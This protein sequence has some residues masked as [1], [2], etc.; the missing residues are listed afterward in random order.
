M[1]LAQ[2]TTTIVVRV[3]NPRTAIVVVVVVFVMSGTNDRTAGWPNL[4][5]TQLAGQYCSICAG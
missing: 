3:A 1:S 4:V 5:W 2:H